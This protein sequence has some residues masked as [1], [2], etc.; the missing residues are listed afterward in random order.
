[1]QINSDEATSTKLSAMLDC[2]PVPMILVGRD[3]AIEAANQRFRSLY[4]G[5]REVL[6]RRC[7]EVAHGSS[8]PCALAGEEC[9]LRSSGR[10]GQTRRA[11]HVHLTPRGLEHVE[12]TV[13]P[14]RD[15]AGEVTSF[16]ESLR[17][18]TIASAEPRGDRLIGRT[19]AFNRMLERIELVAPGDSTV[20]L[21]GEQGSGREAVARA[22]HELSRRSRRPFIAVD[23]S[24]A[25]EPWFEMELFGSGD[26]GPSPS[27]RKRGLMEAADGGTIYL[28]EIG[29]LPAAAQARL[30]RALET[31]TFRHFGGSRP[32]PNDSRLVCS[33][34]VD[35]QRLIDE[36]RF[37]PELWLCISGLSI[38]V[39]PLRDRLGD[40]ELLIE[41]QLQ[42]LESCSGCRLG[43]GTLG[44]LS[45]YTYPGNLRE[46]SALLQ[47]AC[48]LAVD[49]V[50]LPEHLPERIG[51]PRAERS[52]SARSLTKTVE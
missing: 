13:R 38:R 2:F 14:V 48:I 24:G 44:A 30:L 21:A 37:M 27:R 17:P 29:D 6:G 28:N 45:S 52:G 15:S 50:I 7:H 25:R 23:C 22:V 39:P 31:G 35:L 1:M 33:T 4:A 43:D 40:L 42:S 5:D 32:I 41:T 47:H 49:G 18:S 9:P 3:L 16:L 51:E 26:S 12:V 11:L 36:R 10:S 19:P 8:R 34:S 46:L 20:L